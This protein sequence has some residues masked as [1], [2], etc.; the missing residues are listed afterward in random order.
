MV[1]LDQLIVR[2]ERSN[3]NMVSQINSTMIHT[4]RE[5]TSISSKSSSSSYVKSQ[6]FSGWMK[7]TIVISVILI[8]VACI[9]NTAYNI[10]FSF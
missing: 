4:T 2:M 10:C 7:W 9:S 8:A 5:L 3:N 6:I 1:K